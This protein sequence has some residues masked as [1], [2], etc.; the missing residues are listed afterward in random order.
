MNSTQVKLTIVIPVYNERETIHDIIEAVSATPFHKEV[1]VVDD[2]STDKTKTLA[3]AAGEKVNFIVSPRQEN[4]YF[5]HQRNKGIDAAK[6]DWLL[7]LDIDDRVTLEL[8]NEILDS[9]HNV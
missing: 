5:S 8:A 9:I 4:E 2:G 1:I 6:S 3:N 7:H